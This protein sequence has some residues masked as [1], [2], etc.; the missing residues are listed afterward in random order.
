[1]LA[2]LILN[3]AADSSGHNAAS[4][5]AQAAM[6]SLIVGRLG[7]NA[8]IGEFDMAAR[9]RLLDGVR[10]DPKY[11]SRRKQE[12]NP[13]RP[14]IG[15]CVLALVNPV[16]LKRQVYP[17]AR[18]AEFI[19]LCVY[20]AWG[21]LVL[22]GLRGKDMSLDKEKDLSPLAARES[23]KFKDLIFKNDDLNIGIQ[24]PDVLLW[25]NDW[26][27][28]DPL[29][30]FKALVDHPDTYVKCILRG[31]KTKK[32]AEALVVLEASKIEFRDGCFVFWLL[33]IIIHR[34]EFYSELN[35]DYV[36]S[37][38]KCTDR[39]FEHETGWVGLGEWLFL[40]FTKKRFS[41]AWKKFQIKF[42]GEKLFGVHDARRGLQQSMKA[43]N[44]QGG[45]SCDMELRRAVGTW[46]K[47]QKE[48][49]SWYA[50][51]QPTLL[52][53]KWK[54]VLRWD[55]C[56]LCDHLSKEQREELI[57]TLKWVR[58]S[59]RQGLLNIVLHWSPSITLSHPFFQTGAPPAIP[60][61]RWVA[62]LVG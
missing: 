30:I 39:E 35:W 1:M 28:V 45:P 6:R 29:D 54:A 12:S 24:P 23:P 50:G 59:L 7:H 17:N 53:D 5:D 11:L 26:A 33:N 44:L 51:L 38:P 21:S 3:K 47:D 58:F 18:S 60:G 10:N 49:P 22:R 27:G 13:M 46:V 41:E 55:F 2:A 25:G 43:S 62:N 4:S 40:P 9:K 32:E 52:D 34:L 19:L 42:L 8:G 20:K 37:V 61:P 57:A 48:M 56:Q 14:A 16:G 31:F 15:L 36:F